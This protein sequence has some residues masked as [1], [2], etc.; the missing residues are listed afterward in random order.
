VVYACRTSYTAEI[1][2]IIWRRSE[3]IALLVDNLDADD[4]TSIP[5][6]LAGAR[7]VRPAGVDDRARQLPVV[8]PLLTP[9]YRH[10]VVAEARGVGFSLFPPL[11]DPTSVIGSTVSLADGVVVNAAAVLGAQC[12]LELFVHVNRSA[13]IG[14]DNLLGAFSTVGPGSV[15]AGHV[16]VGRGAFIGAGATCAPEVVIGANA[17]VGAGSAVVRDVE[18]GT[19][20]AGNPAKVLRETAGYREVSVPT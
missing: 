17:I 5:D 9:G 14:H 4:G 1:A 7:L 13:S 12:A 20:V 2:E 6:A 19:V 11:L 10:A 15:L 3:R 16:R 8:V 18:P